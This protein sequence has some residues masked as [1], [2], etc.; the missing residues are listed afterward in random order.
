MSWDKIKESLSLHNLNASDIPTGVLGL[1]SVVVL[2]IAFRSAKFM[3]KIMVGVAALVL[4]GAAVW[5]H[6]HNR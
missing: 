1:L 5:W 6:Y 3:S 4:A 2:V